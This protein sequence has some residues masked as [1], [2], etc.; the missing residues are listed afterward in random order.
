MHNSYPV[1]LFQRI[2][3][4]TNIIHQYPEPGHSLLPCDR[5][6][7][8]IE[9]EKRRRERVYVPAEWKEVVRKT[10]KNF[11]V[12]DVTQDMVMDFTEHFKPIFKPAEMGN[13]HFLE[14][15]LMDYGC[16]CEQSIGHDLLVSATAKGNLKIAKLLLQNGAKVNSNTPSDTPLHYAALRHDLKLIQLL[17][18]KGADVNARNAVGETALN[19]L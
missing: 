18:N 13:Y 9:K 12:V 1:L 4:I 11:R 5:S 6:F 10:S 3:S 19:F 15:L 8:L 16:L 17:L 2:K 14:A 7:G